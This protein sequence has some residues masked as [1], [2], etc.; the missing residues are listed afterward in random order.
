MVEPAS[1]SAALAA[2]A[3]LKEVAEVTSEPAADSGA[4]VGAKRKTH[5]VKTSRRPVMITLIID[6]PEMADEKVALLQHKT[7]RAAGSFLQPLPPLCLTAADDTALR[8]LRALQSGSA[9]A[10]AV[11]V[12]PDELMV[13]EVEAEIKAEA[14]TEV[15]RPH[16]QAGQR[17]NI[18]AE[19]Q[20]SSRAWQPTRQLTL[21]C[22]SMCCFRL[23]LQ[24]SLPLLTWMTSLTS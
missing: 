17:S 23:F 11:V 18:R 12:D 3:E 16:D 4:V 19:L 7:Q 20:M 13:P 8:L 22:R 14:D 24:S 9:E 1:A 10:A 15:R 6:Q 2:A 5:A 21:L